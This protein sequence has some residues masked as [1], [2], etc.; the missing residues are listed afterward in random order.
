MYEWTMQHI[1]LIKYPF[2]TSFF[3]LLK[4]N[5]LII[6][7]ALDTCSISDCLTTGGVVTV[8]ECSLEVLEV[9]TEHRQHH[10]TEQ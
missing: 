7:L 8:T 5:G 1:A 4:M 9:G 6:S 10:E 3:N 2:T